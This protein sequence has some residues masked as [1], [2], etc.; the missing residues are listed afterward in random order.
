MRDVAAEIKDLSFCMHIH[1]KRKFLPQSMYKRM[2][3]TK[4]EKE[5]R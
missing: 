5:K 3:M 2:D 4:A 1:N